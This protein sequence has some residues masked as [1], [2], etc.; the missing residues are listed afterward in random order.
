MGL[1]SPGHARRGRYRGHVHRRRHRSRRRREG[2]VAAGRP[3]RRGGRGHRPPAGLAAGPRHDGGDQRPP[4]ASGRRGGAGDQ[5]R[6]G[7]R[8]RDRPAGPALALRPVGRPA[9]ATRGAP[10]PLRRARAAGRRRLRARAGRARRPAADRGRRRRGLPAAQRPRRRT[11]GRGGGAP[12][13][14]RPRRDL[15]PRGVAR[16][17]GV[18]ADG[19]DGRERLPPS[20]LPLLPAGPGWPGAG[21]DRDDLGGRARRPG[22]R[23]RP[24]GRPPALR[25]GGRGAG[26]LGDRGGQRLPWCRRLRHG[27]HV[28]RCLPDRGRSARPVAVV[29][30][31]RLPRP[32]AGVGDPHRGGRRRIG[33]V[34]RP[35]R[36]PAGRP[37][38]GR[39]GAR[40]GLLRARG[41]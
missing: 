30:G 5:R 29:D 13:G 18:R 41:P 38:V 31:R 16:A 10:S 9:T 32:T 36:R 21:G 24:S 35:G 8:D 33:G 23:R 6:H 17:P 28:H 11:R 20:G 40:A 27:R 2:A 34:D 4:G 7:G 26:R 3:G 19:H 15:L 25:P 1:P 12:A 22:L 14:P 37:A 39:S